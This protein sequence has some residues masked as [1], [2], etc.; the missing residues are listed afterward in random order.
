MR[1]KNFKSIFFIT[2]LVVG[3]GTPPQ[4]HSKNSVSTQLPSWI[5]N[6]ASNRDTEAVGSAKAQA[7]PQLQRKIALIKAKAALSESIHLHLQSEVLLRQKSTNTS[8]ESNMETS[9]RQTSSNL[10][11]NAYIKEEFIDDEGVLYILLGL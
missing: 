11:N 10:I 7:N 5:A 1:L 3:C 4:P 8:Y 6:P 9:S 2:F